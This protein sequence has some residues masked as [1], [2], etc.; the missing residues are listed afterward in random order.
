MTQGRRTIWTSLVTLGIAIVFS[1][2]G[3]DAERAFSHSVLS[4]P[5][6]I[7]IYGRP[8]FASGQGYFFIAGVL[9]VGAVIGLLVGVVRLVGNRGP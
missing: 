1:N 2:L 6:A 8:W 7:Q 5:I 9:F 4:D 3:T